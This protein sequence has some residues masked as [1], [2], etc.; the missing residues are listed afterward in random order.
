MS[1]T[2]H[3]ASRSRILP[4]IL[5]TVYEI[6]KNYSLVHRLRR[7]HNIKTTTLA[8]RRVFAGMCE[9]KTLLM[10]LRINCLTNSP[11]L[12]Y[13]AGGGQVN[14]HTGGMLGDVGGDAPPPYNPCAGPPIRSPEGSYVP[15]SQ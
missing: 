3:A 6:I 15:G 13:P 4:I 9:A 14:Q 2:K 10:L 8:Q 5:S 12:F 7:W 11:L 1:A